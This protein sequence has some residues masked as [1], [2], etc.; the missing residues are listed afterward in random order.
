MNSLGVATF[1]IAITGFA[2]GWF[3]GA[4]FMANS[5]ESYK[6][7]MKEGRRSGFSEGIDYCRGN[8]TTIVS[9]N[10]SQS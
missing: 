4:V 3:A 10:R 5:F 8:A 1:L 7:G 9:S 6:R 2:G